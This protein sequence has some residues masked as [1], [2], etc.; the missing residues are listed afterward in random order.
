MLDPLFGQLSDTNK[1]ALTSKSINVAVIKLD[2]YAIDL[3]I[4]DLHI[5]AITIATYPNRGIS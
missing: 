3:L 5:S 2:M 1:R 4:N